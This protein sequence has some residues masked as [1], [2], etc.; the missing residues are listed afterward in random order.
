MQPMLCIDFGNSYT[1]VAIRKRTHPRTLPLQDESLTEP[2][3]DQSLKWDGTLFVCIPSTV[4]RT[5][6]G[7]HQ[8]Y[9]YGADVE[10]VSLAR[11][12]DPSTK[13]YRNWK[14]LFFQQ[15]ADRIPIAA[16]RS[17][18]GAIDPPSSVD[19]SAIKA[20][21]MQWIADHVAS[22]GAPEGIVTFEQWKAVTASL[23][24]GTGPSAVAASPVSRLVPASGAEID[25]VAQGYF[26]WLKTFIQNCV[27]PTGREDITNIPCR[28][29]LPSFGNQSAAENRLLSILQR[30]GWTSDDYAVVHEP[31]ANAI[32]LFTMGRN[33]TWTPAPVPQSPHPREEL[34][35]PAMFRGTPIYQSMRANARRTRNA[36]TGLATTEAPYWVLTIDIGGFT[37]DFSM[38]GLDLD[39]IGFL[40]AEA[41]PPCRLA[42]HS[43]VA[44]VR[45]LDENVIS[46]LPVRKQEQLTT[47]MNS[48]DQ[49]ALES[50]HQS[51]YKNLE[52][53]RLVAAGVSLIDDDAERDSLMRVLREFSIQI[54]SA[55]DD[56][57]NRFQFP[58]VDELVLTGGGFNCPVIRN[59]VMQHVRDKYAAQCFI[60]PM[61]EGEIVEGFPSS[62]CR[63]VD[64]I[65]LRASTA[66][67]GASVLFDFL[68][69]NN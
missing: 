46:Q 22:G 55:L 32:G 24:R 8:R 61:D 21:Y 9:Y 51:V 6:E 4:V 12:T 13:V 68:T 37:T 65:S 16:S 38:L 49:L 60:V 62:S 40:D 27:D 5:T 56:F 30:A 20:A 28:I 36:A 41:G 26:S 14:P 53:F 7:S 64:P 52:Q 66:I 42:K 18:V 31:L 58:S 47:M 29:T 39:D 69:A 59:T 19:E 15:P 63:R 1:K 17:D 11:R 25:Q 33:H 35:Y 67:G 2:V 34:A 48:V 45:H 50:F 57:M 10:Q 54:C 43:V 3:K 44:G 23:R